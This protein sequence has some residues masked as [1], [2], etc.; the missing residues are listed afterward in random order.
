[1]ILCP[2]INHPYTKNTKTKQ[3]ETERKHKDDLRDGE[4]HGILIFTNGFCT[5]METSKDPKQIPNDVFINSQAQV[6]FLKMSK[7]NTITLI[8]IPGS[9]IF[10]QHFLCKEG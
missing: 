6:L 10:G 8:R 4:N 9:V 2:Q 1:M 3:N 7:L 5:L